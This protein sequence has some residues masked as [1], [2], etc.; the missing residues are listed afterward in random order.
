[1]ASGKSSQECLPSKATGYYIIKAAEHLL[2]LHAGQPFG[3]RIRTGDSLFAIE[4]NKRVGDALQEARRFLVWLPAVISEL[5]CS[6]SAKPVRL[7]FQFQVFDS[8]RVLP[9]T[10]YR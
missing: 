1:M 5:Q 10:V 4:R 2:T 7:I 6:S 8:N 9:S 3:R